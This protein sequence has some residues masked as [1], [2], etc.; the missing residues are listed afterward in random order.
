MVQSAVLQEMH[1]RVKNSLQTIA[2]LLRLQ[3]R[4]G[5]FDS[6]QVAL[7]QSINRIQSIAAVH[8][9]L[10]KDNL[11][12]VNLKKLAENILSAT[13]HGL[14]PDARTIKTTVIGDNYMLPSSQATYVSL[15]L[16]EL[17]QNA[18]EHGFGGKLGSE[19]SVSV[20]H[21]EDNVY[22]DVIN[23]GDPLPTDFDIQKNQNLGLKI[24]ESL[25][26][27]NL[28]GEFGIMTQDGKTKAWVK[29]PK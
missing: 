2:S 24:V 7:N 16:N 19:L 12:D 18:M 20:A 6:P 5:K 29:F 3:V 26:H 15:I 13:A 21:D 10:S 1:H 28:L 9:M 11:D 8:E 4:M 14:L 27:D 25:V 22:L 17:I 23:D